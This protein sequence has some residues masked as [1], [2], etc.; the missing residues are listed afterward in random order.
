MIEIYEKIVP[1]DLVEQELAEMSKMIEK[2]INLAN[3]TNDLKKALATFLEMLDINGTVKNLPFDFSRGGGEM[4]KVQMD[5]VDIACGKTSECDKEL[6]R[7]VASAEEMVMLS[8]RTVLP[9]SVLLSFT[10]HLWDINMNL[11][12][13]LKH[14]GILK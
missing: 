7:I 3:E 14:L 5:L 11:P 8:Y 13:R 10:E 6:K 1:D 9:S 4:V 12:C 2:V